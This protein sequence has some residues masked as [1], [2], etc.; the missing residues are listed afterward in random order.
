MKFVIIGVIFLTAVG[1]LLT[2]GFMAGNIPHYQIHELTSA[3]YQGE[4][5][6]VDGAKVEEFVENDSGPL[7][8]RVEAPNGAKLNVVSKRRKPDNFKVGAGVGLRGYYRASEAVFEAN[9][10]TTACPSKYEAEDGKYK[11]PVEMPG[12]T[13]PSTPES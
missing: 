13:T 1:A 6:R 3:A 11:A 10:I 8:F 5:C 9:D 4:E 2:I 12:V 7:R